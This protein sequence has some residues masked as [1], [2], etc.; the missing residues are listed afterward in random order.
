MAECDDICSSHESSDESVGDLRKFIAKFLTVLAK[1][2]TFK[3]IIPSF[4][5][6]N[7][8]IVEV[9]LHWEK[10]EDGSSKLRV[11]D[12]FAQLCE[13]LDHPLPVIMC[14]KQRNDYA[15]MIKA[16]AEQ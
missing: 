6:Y 8:K 13:D 9:K 2:N 10:C 1:G 7:A 16:S 3:Y 11:F 15:F 14:N 12:G 5:A 4:P